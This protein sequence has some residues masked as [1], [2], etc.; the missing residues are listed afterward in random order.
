MAW[1]QIA[2]TFLTTSCQ[3]HPLFQLPVTL[4]ELYLVLILS[5]TNP[6][7]TSATSSVVVHGPCDSVKLLPLSALFTYVSGSSCVSVHCFNV[8]CTQ[9]YMI[10]KVKQGTTGT[11][12]P[13]KIAQVNHP[14]HRRL[15]TACQFHDPNRGLDPYNP[16]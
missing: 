5:T 1:A 11:A 13:P 16:R 4:R 6:T 10:A 15:R 14:I 8:H 7:T 3:M 2:L 9:C 12:V